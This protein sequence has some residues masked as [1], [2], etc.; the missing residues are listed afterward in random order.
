MKQ[1]LQFRGRGM[2]PKSTSG[3][4]I[5]AR[6]GRTAGISIGETVIY[7]IVLALVTGGGCRPVPKH[8]RIQ[9]GDRGR[10]GDQ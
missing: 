3:R 5:N 4:E 10:G 1:L 2:R 9:A 8:Q 7:A 6:Q